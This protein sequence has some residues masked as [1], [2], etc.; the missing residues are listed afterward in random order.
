[1]AVRRP[2]R[3]PRQ[4]APSDPNI[5]LRTGARSSSQKRSKSKTLYM[6]YSAGIQFCLDL[7]RPAYA[8]GSRSGTS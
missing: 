4:L 3:H 6:I 2:D 7:Y 1:M 5:V 8:S